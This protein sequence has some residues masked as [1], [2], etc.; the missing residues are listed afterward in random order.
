MHSPCG[1]A[2]IITNLETNDSEMSED[3]SLFAPPKNQIM[4]ENGV[5]LKKVLGAS[6]SNASSVQSEMSLQS[7]ANNHRLPNENCGRKIKALHFPGIIS[8]A[9][10]NLVYIKYLV[11]YMMLQK[12]LIVNIYFV[13]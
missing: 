10:G 2:I 13:W 12:P 4:D 3:R 9:P 5:K 7:D 1:N 8:Q 6:D 11:L